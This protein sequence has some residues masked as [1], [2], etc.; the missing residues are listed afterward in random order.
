MTNPS[1]TTVMACKIF[2]NRRSKY[3][4][5]KIFNKLHKSD[6]NAVNKKLKKLFNMKPLTVIK[7]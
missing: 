4:M 1:Y 3:R 2:D 5:K 6:Q 7:Y